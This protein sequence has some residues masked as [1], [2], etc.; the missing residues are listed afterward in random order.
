VSHAP[1][2]LVLLGHP[3]AHSLSPVMQNAALSALGVRLHYEAVD[4]PPDALD[5]TLDALIADGAAGNVTLPHKP[6]VAARCASLTARA[7][8]AGAV[9]TFRVV[10]GALAGD[11]TDIPAFA[12]L[13]AQTLGGPAVSRRIAVLGAGGG[14]AA[15][16][17]AAEQWPECTVV[18]HNRSPV[19]AAELAS[20]FPIVTEIAST[21]EVAVQHASLVVNATSL[22]L[23][24]LDPLPVPVEQLTPSAAVVDLVYRPGAS[25]WVRAA[26]ARGHRAADG[27]EMLLEQGALALETWLGVPAPREVMR[28]ALARHA[29]MGMA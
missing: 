15:V 8:R 27:L 3:V 12:A 21:A 14:A 2:R 20:R 1:R 17:A 18:L 9:N 28:E 16:L 11:N 13:V 29:G 7:A 24:D 6:R 10:D 4:V 5:A 23:R 25:A 19:R 26:R 22:G